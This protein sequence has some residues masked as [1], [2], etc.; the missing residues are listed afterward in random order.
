[1]M[2]FIISA[3]DIK[4]TLHDYD[5]S[6]SESV[7]HQSAKLADEAFNTALKERIEPK[8]ILL[9]GGAASGKTE[10][11]SAYLYNEDAVIFDATMRSF[12]GAKIKIEKAQKAGKIVEIIL[13]LPQ[14]IK[15]AFDAF[16]H[17]DRKFPVEHFYST[18]ASARQAVLQVTQRLD[19]PI[20][21][22]QSSYEKTADKKK[23]VFDEIV[24]HSPADLLEFMT[25]QQYTVNEIRKI[26]TN[27]V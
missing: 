16:L 20:K 22:Y 26:I 12:T 7:H 15:V 3:G 11:I 21:I 1:M 27:E 25:N 17:R 24:I 2:A 5:P 10:Y 8:V 23:I 19:I 18:H 6:K 13:V 4:K 9:A 14:D